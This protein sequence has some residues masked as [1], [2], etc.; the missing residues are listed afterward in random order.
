MEYVNL[1]CKEVLTLESLAAEMFRMNHIDH[2]HALESLLNDWNQG[3][4]ATLIAET[5]H[6]MLDACIAHGEPA[7][8]CIGDLN[9]TGFDDLDAAGFD[10]LDAAGFCDFYGA[11]HDDL[12]RT[13]HEDLPR[14]SPCDPGA[15]GCAAAGIAAGVAAYSRSEHSLVGAARG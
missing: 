8:T 10:D 14:A 13:G 11:G 12:P 1:E 3:C 5:A 7:V 2:D 15:C 4:D 6:K 9:A